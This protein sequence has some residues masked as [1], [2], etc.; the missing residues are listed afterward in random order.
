M[1]SYKMMIEGHDVEFTC[2]AHDTRN[3]FKHTATMWIDG[4][5]AGSHTCYY[6][7]RTW[8]SYAYQTVCRAIAYEK[9]EETVDGIRREWMAARGYK[10]M[11]AGRRTEWKKFPAGD[12]ERVRFWQGVL[13]V[14][15][16]VFPY[17]GSSLWYAAGARER[18]ILQDLGNVSRTGRKCYKLEN[19]AGDRFCVF[20]IGRSEYVN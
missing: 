5:R 1:K 16:S 2:D 17:G 13:F 20:H 7:N 14:L 12:N 8:E 9:L 15:C 18:E 6:L 19:A 10:R 11:T 3:G 4:R